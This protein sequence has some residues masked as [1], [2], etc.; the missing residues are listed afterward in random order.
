M[1]WAVL[2]RAVS[3]QAVMQ[4]MQ[5]V[6]FSAIHTGVSRRA[7]YL[8]AVRPVEAAIMPTAAS[9]EAG[10]S[11]PRSARNSLSNVEICASGMR[12]PWSGLGRREGMSTEQ[13]SQAISAGSLIDDRS[14][15]S[16]SPY[17]TS[18]TSS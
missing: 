18:R 6:Q 8:E 1:S 13:P 2:G 17:G 11:Y 9:G 5:A 14:D 7:T 16:I 4:S 15:A 3:G 10:W 12:T